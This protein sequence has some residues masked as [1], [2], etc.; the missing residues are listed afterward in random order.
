MEKKKKKSHSAGPVSWDMKG[1]L[2]VLEIQ[3]LY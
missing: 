3:E 1:L 2:C